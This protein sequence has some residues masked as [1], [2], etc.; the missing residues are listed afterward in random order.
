MLLSSSGRSH[1]YTTSCA[2]SYAASY[3]ASCAVSYA[4]RRCSYLN[5]EAMQARC[6]GNLCE[7]E[8]ASPRG[9]GADIYS[10]DFT[11]CSSLCRPLLCAYRHGSLRTPPSLWLP[12]N[13]LFGCPSAFSWLCLCFLL[14]CPSAFS[15]AVPPPS[16]GCA[17]RFQALLAGS[18]L[19]LQ[20]RPHSSV[21]TCLCSAGLT[22]RF[23]PCS[24]VQA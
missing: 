14:G 13:P 8:A 7:S 18:G 9:D 6:A 20:R 4:G 23:R 12:L 3:A 24:A 11:L 16:P 19:P 21:Q 10:V 1:I 17:L 15:L 22:L 2:A 5:S